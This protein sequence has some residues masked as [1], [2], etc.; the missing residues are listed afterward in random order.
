MDLSTYIRQLDHN[1]PAA[2]QRLLQVDG[3]RVDYDPQRA[4]VGGP[5]FVLWQGAQPVGA[6]CVTSAAQSDLAS[7]FPH[8]LLT[9]YYHFRFH[10]QTA[11]LDNPGNL[12]R[13]LKQFLQATPP[14]TIRTP[15]ALTTLVGQVTDR[16]RGLIEAVAG[17]DAPD[18][19]W[20]AQRAAWPGLPLETFASEYAQALVF[21]LLAARLRH[22]GFGRQQPFALRDAIWDQPSTN[23]FMRDLYRQ[24][25]RFDTRL[26]WLLAVLAQR[27]DHTDLP[28]IL[29]ELGRRARHDDLLAPVVDDFQ[30]QYSPAARTLRLATPLV[31]YLVDSV[32]YLLQRRFKRTLGLADRDVGIWLPDVEN[33]AV[34]FFIIQQ[35]HMALRHH[36]Q[37]GAWDTFVAD[38]L[39]PRLAGGSPSLSQHALA[40]LKASL[41]LHATGYTFHNNQRLPVYLR[42]PAEPAGDFADRLRAEN[43]PE[44]RP[45]HPLQVTIGFPD[46]EPDFWS[47]ML[48]QQRSGGIAALVLPGDFLDSETHRATRARLADFYHDLYLIHLPHVVL[49]VLVR[50]TQPNRR[51]LYYMTCAEKDWLTAHPFAGVNWQEINPASKTWRPDSHPPGRLNAGWHIRDILPYSQPGSA[52]DPLSFS[53]EGRH[54]AP[55]LYRP[56]DM[57]YRAGSAPQHTTLALSMSSGSVL[58]TRYPI[59]EA[60]LGTP[61]WQHPLYLYNSEIVSPFAPGRDGRQPNLHPDFI[62]YL[63][64]HLN[65]TFVTDGR[66]DL[67]DSFGPEDVFHYVYA[68]LHHQGLQEQQRIPRPQSAKQFRRLARAGRDLTRAHLLYRAANWTVRSGFHGSSNRVEPGYP[69]FMELAGEPGGRIYINSD[70]YFTGIER[71]VW[72]MRIGSIAV[73]RDWLTAREGYYLT[74]PDIWHFQIVAAALDR[75]ADV[76]SRIQELLAD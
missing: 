21:G 34:V 16:L 49:A 64:D 76:L 54:V 67:K 19:D 52:A 20:R 36:H 27:L 2:L 45:E 18:F 62:L 35:A 53:A 59:H 40:H 55:L 57:R 70:K 13:L 72:Q 29:Q 8:L 6:I 63:A 15:A 41:Y 60:L 30:A 9:D 25:E 26:A 38:D 58:A 68:V 56:F 74:W 10:E 66:G 37:L 11:A 17:G 46:A 12:D 44:Q 69:R 28:H 65:L 51:H 5:D 4:T 1:Q 48:A 22:E 43:L 42:L 39:L 24:M 47:Q 23:P 71:H 3:Q 75:S 61:T 14:P 31:H 32:H 33:G 73:L 50:R 7:L